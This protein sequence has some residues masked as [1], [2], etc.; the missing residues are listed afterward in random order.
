MNF[1]QVADLLS[2]TSVAMTKILYCVEVNHTLF[3][4]REIYLPSLCTKDMILFLLNINDPS[5]HAHM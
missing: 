4:F 2:S 3:S 1:S 5:T